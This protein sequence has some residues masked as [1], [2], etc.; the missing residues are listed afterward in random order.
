MKRI[1]SLVLVVIMVFGLCACGGASLTSESCVGVW[2]WD[3]ENSGSQSV[4]IETMELL[5]GGIGRGTTSQMTDGSYY[6]LL[7]EVKDNIL[8]VSLDMSSLSYSFK[9]KEAKL[10]STDGTIVYSKK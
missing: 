1:C 9:L 10:V 6:P 7:W 2:M 5:E 8:V 3:V 4:I